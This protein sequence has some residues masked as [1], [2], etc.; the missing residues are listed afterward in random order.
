MCSESEFK[1]LLVGTIFTLFVVPA[2]WLVAD[3][4]QGVGWHLAG[5]PINYANYS[6]Q[7]GPGTRPLTPIN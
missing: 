3:S 1:A 5:L 4:I 7:V 6:C 2:V